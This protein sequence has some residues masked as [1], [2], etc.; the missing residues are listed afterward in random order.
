MSD[1][2]NQS[3]G[4]SRTAPQEKPDADAVVDELLVDAFGDV[5]VDEK[6]N[7]AEGAKE[8]AEGNDEDEEDEESKEK[9]PADDYVDEE[10][11]K[12]EEESLTEDQLKE[13]LEDARALKEL[14]NQEFAAEELKDSILSYTKA[15]LVCLLRENE[16]RA[17]LYSNRSASKVKLGHKESALDDCGLSLKHNPTYMKPLIRR[18]KLFEELDKLD[19]ALADYQKIVEL[20]PGNRDARVAVQRLPGQIAERNEKLKTEMLGKLKDLGNM[21]L[22]P[23]GLSTE[24]FQLQ[25]DP[26]SGGYSI[27]FKK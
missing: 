12:K 25:Q 17:V 14:G 1:G 27:N 8:S 2:D 10:K 20:D 22:R 7:N 13:R 15:L 6:L 9:K 18:A 21:V 11:L 5:H 19:E 24:N 26:N 16:L 23:F 3:K 4:D